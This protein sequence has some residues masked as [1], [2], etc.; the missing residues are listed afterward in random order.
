M[1]EC[2]K[3]IIIIYQSYI[4]TVKKIT[5]T[6][7][8][9]YLKFI[10]TLAGHFIVSDVNF[11]YYCIKFL[12]FIVFMVLKTI[13]ELPCR[14]FLHRPLMALIFVPRL[15]INNSDLSVHI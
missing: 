8:V 9:F 12:V 11:I 5:K 15:G 14:P 1:A 4:Y 6:T 7:L 10:A 13:T 2:S 3:Q